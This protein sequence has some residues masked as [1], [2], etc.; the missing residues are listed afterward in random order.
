MIIKV[1]YESCKC[2]YH[3]YI[4]NCNVTGKKDG[5]WYISI[6]GKTIWL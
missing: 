1:E 5:N 2:C 3:V 4:F 6:V